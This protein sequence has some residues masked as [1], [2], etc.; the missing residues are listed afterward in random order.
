MQDVSHCMSGSGLMVTLAVW[1]Q[2]NITNV[3]SVKIA[4]H[5][6]PHCQT[7]MWHTEWLQIL[8]TRAQNTVP[9]LLLL[10]KVIISKMS[11]Q[12]SSEQTV[13]TVLLRSTL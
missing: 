2:R 8:T 7:R 13:K 4:P 6:P 11:M 1:V 9:Q 3:W 10:F 12:R 5:S